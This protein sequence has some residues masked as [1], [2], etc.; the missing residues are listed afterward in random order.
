MSKNM[1]S[2]PVALASGRYQPKWII[3]ESAFAHCLLA[4]D[5]DAAESAM[6]SPV[7]IKLGELHSGSG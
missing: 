5:D 1:A 7:F 2:A 3:P 6:A 4:L